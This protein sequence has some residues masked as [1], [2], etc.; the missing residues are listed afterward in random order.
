MY[1]IKKQTYG[2]ILTFADP[3]TA[4]ELIHFRVES[5]RSLV[6]VPKNF[7]M[8]ID[9]SEFHSEA[10]DEDARR[11]M[12]DC[13]DLYRRHGALRTCVVLPDGTT[14]G[15]Y[16]HRQRESP[17]TKFYERYLNA[18]ALPEWKTAAVNW[19]SRGVE[20]YA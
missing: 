3:L 8:I 12:V 10:L 16:R 7:G 6:G 18:E 9:L 5:V 2:F 11:E 20:P 15:K 14:T 19:V 13:L 1:T 17:R 4:D